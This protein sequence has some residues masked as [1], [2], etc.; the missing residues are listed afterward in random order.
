MFE[1]HWKDTL[2]L[3]KVICAKA[4]ISI[5]AIDKNGLPPCPT[6]IYKHV[7]LDANIGPQM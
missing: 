4:E 6:Y 1:W 2:L 3:D 5:F 7:V